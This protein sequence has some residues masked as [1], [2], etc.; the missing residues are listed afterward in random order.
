MRIAVLTYGLPDIGAP[1]ASGICHTL[2]GPAQRGHAVSTI[3]DRPGGDVRRLPAAS[4]EHVGR[5][6]ND[7]REPQFPMLSPIIAVRRTV[8]GDV[9]CR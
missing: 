4:C 6:A 5:A 2:A 8:D 9:C 7:H 1:A 3:Q